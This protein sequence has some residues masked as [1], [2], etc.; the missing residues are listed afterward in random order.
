MN[1]KMLYRL[2]HFVP[3]EIK[4]DLHKLY[5]VD[6]DGSNAEQFCASNTK[7]LDT[8]QIIPYDSKYAEANKGKFVA[9]CTGPKKE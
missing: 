5:R 8:C 3:W 2:A 6:F 7:L 1:L 9:V 4:E